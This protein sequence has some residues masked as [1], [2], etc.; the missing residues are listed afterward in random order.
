[1][2]NIC[3]ITDNKYDVLFMLI[4]SMRTRHSSDF[5]AFASKF[6][7]ETFRDTFDFLHFIKSFIQYFQRH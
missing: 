7:E 6:H 4:S 2:Y 1:M 3:I 5:V